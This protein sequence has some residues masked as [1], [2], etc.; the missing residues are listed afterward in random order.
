[1]LGVQ[2]DLEMKKTF[3]LE[4]ALAGAKVVTRDGEEVT[5]LIL[6]NIDSKIRPPLFGV[7]K[8]S[9][10]AWFENGKYTDEDYHHLDLF[11]ATTRKTMYVAR[12]DDG[13]HSKCYKTMRE[14]I[15]STI[16]AKSFHEIEI[17]E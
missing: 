6:F 10:T 11:M 9:I 17:E 1:M 13:S 2:E 8:G 12:Y 7:Y 4:A 15:C 5:Q 16:S 3:D 14:C